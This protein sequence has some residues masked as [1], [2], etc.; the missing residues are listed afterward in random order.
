MPAPQEN[1]LG[2]THYLLYSWQV[3]PNRNNKQSGEGASVH[4]TWSS[5]AGLGS[6]HSAL[7]ILNNSRKTTSMS[8]DSGF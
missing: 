5:K 3:K 6:M 8:N 1:E 4:R 2:S 7:A